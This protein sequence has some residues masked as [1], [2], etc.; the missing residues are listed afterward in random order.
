[1]LWRTL[2]NEMSA[3]EQV[4]MRQGPNP[5]P[6]GGSWLVALRVSGCG[7][8]WRPSL[9]EFVWRPPE[10]WLSSTMQ[11]R[12]LGTPIVLGHP[13]TGTLD[14]NSF[15]DSVVGIV[16][17]AFVRQGQ[18]WATGRFFD[19]DIATAICDPDNKLMSCD[20]SPAVSFDPGDTAV[21]KLGDGTTL[22]VENSPNAIDHVA[23]VVGKAG[24]AGG[25]WSK[26]TPNVGIQT[27]ELENA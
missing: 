13:A 1:M 2:M 4:A 14:A 22:L 6:F 17:F 7:V 19:Q 27:E 18:L 12:V 15:R 24:E 21:V 9:N 5:M 16:V 25:V 23:L 26:G 11:R 20:T 8:A 10:I 3:A